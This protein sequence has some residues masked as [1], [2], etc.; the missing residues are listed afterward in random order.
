MSRILIAG[1]YYICPENQIL[2]CSTTNRDGYR[3]YKFWEYEHELIKRRASFAGVSV[4][5]FM[6]ELALKGYVVQR[7]VVEL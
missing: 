3:E 4:N 2:S 5:T 7:N 6:R 1:E